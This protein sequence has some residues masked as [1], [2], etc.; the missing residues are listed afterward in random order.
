MK[1]NVLFYLTFILTTT[2]SSVVFAQ[3]SSKGF[4]FQG[5]AIDTDGK[6]IASQSVQVRFSL[7]SINETFTETHNPVTTDIF[8]VFHAVI[9]NSSLQKNNEF[10]QLSF[11]MQSDDDYILKVEISQDG[12]TWVTTNNH[13]MNAVGYARHAHNG[14]AV[15]TVLPFAGNASNIPDGWF[16]CD[17]ALVDTSDYRQL[18][19]AIGNAWGGSG[20][21]F[22]LPDMR[23]R[24]IRGIDDGAGRDPNAATRLT[25]ATGG[26]SGVNVGSVQSDEIKSHTHT[27]RTG[28]GGTNDGAHTHE[29]RRVYDRLIRPYSD[30][31]FCTSA[32]VPK[33]YDSSTSTG[34]TGAHTHTIEIHD[35][36]ETDSRP[37]N[38]AVNY[39]I[40]Y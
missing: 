8:G 3:T 17:G 19:T 30:C 15:G 2:L 29:Y 40:K 26:N 9:G 37:I 11:S 13:S 39:I 35:R 18:Y 24:F 20:T 36:G 33:N 16:L 25:S 27:G 1:L 22:N 38:A 12:N 14:A 31:T 5:Y 21:Q 10:K 23:G 6:A 7:T 4:S 32:L 34:I 28:P